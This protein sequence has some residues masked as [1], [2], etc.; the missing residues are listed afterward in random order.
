VQLKRGE[1]RSSSVSVQR[2]VLARHGN[3]LEG[4]V[5]RSTV[6]WS[7][8]VSAPFSPLVAEILLSH[9]TL[10]LEGIDRIM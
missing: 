7:A 8:P 1:W 9:V 6:T 4:W 10:E 3:T 2:G 5:S